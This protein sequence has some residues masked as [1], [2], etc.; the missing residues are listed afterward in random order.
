MKPKAF[1]GIQKVQLAIQRPH[2]GLITCTV[3]YAILQFVNMARAMHL[4]ASMVEI[5]LVDQTADERMTQP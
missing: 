5:G 4:C 1:D 2:V 3:R